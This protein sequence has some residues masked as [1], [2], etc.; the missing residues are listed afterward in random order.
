MALEITDQNFEELVLNS[1]KPVI[2]DFWAEWC[3]P[4]KMMAPILTKL[5]KEYEGKA[6]II[7]IDVW[8]DKSQ[9]SK[10]GIK[11]I[12]TQ[13]FYDKEGNEVFPAIQFR[14]IENFFMH[15]F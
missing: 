2:V 10:F 9:G 6:A 11:S 14:L 12:P 8:E 7:F 5:T 15:F 13:I 4:C 1:E 3:G